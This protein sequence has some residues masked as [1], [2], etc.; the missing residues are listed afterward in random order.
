[1]IEA[2]QGEE[3]LTAQMEEAAGETQATDIE[4]IAAADEA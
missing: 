3:V 2:N 1:V 4:E